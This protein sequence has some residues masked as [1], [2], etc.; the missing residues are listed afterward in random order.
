MQILQYG[1]EIE[2]AGS[3]VMDEIFNSFSIMY[4]HYIEQDEIESYFIAR[5]DDGEIAG[6]SGIGYCG[7]TVLVEAKKSGQ[8]TGSALVQSAIEAGFKKAWMPRQNGAEE[9]WAKMEE[10]FGF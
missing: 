5:S 3:E 6:F 7:R 1:K 8:G 10:K 4:E 9:F 2:E